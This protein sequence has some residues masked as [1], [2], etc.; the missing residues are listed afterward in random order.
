M[1]LRF[2]EI[3]LQLK[4]SKNE[5]EELRK[6][7]DRLQKK[8]VDQE[9]ATLHRTRRNIDDGSK[10][11]P[12]IVDNDMPEE[13]MQSS[14]N[15][16]PMADETKMVAF[17]AYRDKPFHEDQKYITFD[18]MKVNVGGGFDPDSGMVTK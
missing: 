3:D 6:S 16:M 17:D 1:L 10:D 8:M 14:I 5:N 11:V 12:I 2:N 7:L 13:R 15:A 18:G 4:R 9:G